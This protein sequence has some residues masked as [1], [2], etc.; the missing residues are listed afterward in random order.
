MTDFHRLIVEWYRLNKRDLPWRETQNAY[1]IWLSEIIL[2]QTR[3]LQGMNYYLKFIRHYPTVHDLANA[4][5]Q[6]VL[7]DWQGLGYYSRA[8][9]L[10]FTAKLISKEMNGVFPSSFDE[11][12]KLKGIGDY[13]AAAISSFAY[14]LP[15]AV[16]DGNVYRVLS[17]VFEVRFPIDS[18]DGKKYFAELA[19]ELISLQEPAVHNQAIMELGAMQ[20][21][22]HN[23]NCDACPI[24]H[25]CYAF[26][27]N[28]IK[29]LPI[30]SKKLVI[31]KRFFNYLVF[32]WDAK[33]ILQKRGSNDIWAH[34]YE[35][36][37][38]ESEGFDSRFSVA[39]FSS[40][41]PVFSS[42]TVKHILSHQHLYVNFHVFHSKPLRLDESWVE[43]E[44]KDFHNF[45][46]PR[47]IDRFVASLKLTALSEMY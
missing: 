16:V 36:P 43:I 32:I 44:L 18:T 33:I 47:V 46:I 3:V 20:C 2:Q 29:K 25:K 26:E 38:I 21:I 1:F 24:S 34:L 10:H 45:P 9:N 15:H 39:P 4:S 23:P 42:E 7:N 37:L 19:Q 13:T 11:I 27:K 14:N 28:E 41:K 22:P 31:K 17:R 12:K 30:K 40:N 35:F 5:E 8:R 6:D